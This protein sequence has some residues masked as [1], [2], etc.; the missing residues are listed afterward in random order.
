MT[1]LYL[2][3]GLHWLASSDVLNTD[4]SNTLLAPGPAECNLY[5]RMWTEM[6]S[7]LVLTTIFKFIILSIILLCPAS[8]LVL[9]G[10]P[11][12]FAFFLSN[13]SRITF[14]LNINSDALM[15]L[16]LRLRVLR[17]RKISVP[18][19]R[20]VEEAYNL[21]IPKKE[22][23]WTESSSYPTSSLLSGQPTADD[24]WNLIGTT[25]NNVV[26]YHDRK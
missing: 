6:S 11:L 12:G 17:G 1:R 15:L 21:K 23:P 9:T 8:A 7:I 4:N 22:A 2:G 24:H 16:D 18:K 25:N 14:F 13:I 26:R 5:Q 10:T 19:C 20:R 3:N